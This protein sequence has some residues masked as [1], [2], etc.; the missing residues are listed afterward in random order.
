[1]TYISRREKVFDIP[2]HETEASPPV[3][4]RSDHRLKRF[5]SVNDR[6]AWT[7]EECQRYQHLY[8]LVSGSK[9]CTIMWSVVL[10]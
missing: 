6:R 10:I 3:P 8:G 9:V 1:M 5:P 2:E 4:K 7:L